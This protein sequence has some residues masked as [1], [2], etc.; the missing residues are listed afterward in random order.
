MSEST[1]NP[2]TFLNTEVT[3]ANSTT[4]IPIPEGEYPALVKTIKPRSTTSGKSILDVLWGIDDAEVVRITGN[5][6]PVSRQSIFLDLTDSGGLDFGKG[7]NVALGKL[8][9]A[10]GQNQSGKPWAPGMLL[11]QVARVKIVHREYEGTI[12][13]DIRGVT[14]L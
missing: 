4:Y 11:G 7:K 8:R 5:D 10:V 9:E 12:I 2:D 14:A 3:E 13:P 1:F 6:K